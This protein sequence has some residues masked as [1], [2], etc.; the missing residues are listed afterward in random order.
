MIPVTACLRRAHPLHYLQNPAGFRAL[1]YD[2]LPLPRTSSGRPTDPLRPHLDPKDP[3]PLHHEAF[4]LPALKGLDFPSVI[5][6]MH[7]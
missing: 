5:Q 7:H 1:G 3:I 2:P 6:V 4:L